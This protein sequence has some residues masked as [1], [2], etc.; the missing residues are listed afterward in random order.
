[1]MR[2]FTDIIRIGGAECL[3]EI[4]NCYSKYGEAETIV[5]CR[6]NKQANRYNTGIRNQILWREEE[7]SQGDLLMVVKNNYFW[8]KEAGDIDFIANGDILKLERV[9]KHHDLYNAHFVDV[10]L[11][12]LDYKELS[13]EAQVNV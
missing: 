8:G 11:N 3:Q 6:S 9:T 5:I 7:I 4:E 1:M 10:W 12:F 2:K 13:F